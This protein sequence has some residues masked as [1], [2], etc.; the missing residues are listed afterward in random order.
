M[1][2]SC[3]HVGMDQAAIRMRR[4]FMLGANCGIRVSDI[5]SITAVEYGTCNAK[6]HVWCGVVA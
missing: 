6:M 3:T 5:G 4:S 1:V 2:E